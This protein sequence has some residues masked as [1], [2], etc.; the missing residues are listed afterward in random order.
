MLN[1]PQVNVSTTGPSLNLALCLYLCPSVFVCPG[2]LDEPTACKYLTLDVNT[3][4]Y[5]KPDRN[6]RSY[7]LFYIARNIK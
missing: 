3:P 5:Y 1:V 6:L 4:W 7:F 2:V